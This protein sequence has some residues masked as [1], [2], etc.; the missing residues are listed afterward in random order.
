MPHFKGREIT[1]AELTRLFKKGFT[2]LIEDLWKNTET[3][4]YVLYGV[5]FPF[6]RGAGV[7]RRIYI[8][9]DNE[10]KIISK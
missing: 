3:N 2:V 10:P 1:I 6:S 5:L 8:S 4:N 9:F 7:C